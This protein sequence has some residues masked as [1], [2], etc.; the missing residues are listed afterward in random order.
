ME[1]VNR[2]YSKQTDVKYIYQLERRVQWRFNGREKRKTI[3][4][5]A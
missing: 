1:D 5:E 2:C 3:L 4:P